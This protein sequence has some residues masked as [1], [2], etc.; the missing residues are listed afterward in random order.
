MTWTVIWEKVRSIMSPLIKVLL[1]AVIGHMIVTYTVRLMR[2]V[3]KRSKLDESLVRFLEKTVNI[4]LHILVV[5]SAL[6]SVG[7]STG[8]FVAA[9]SAVAV[10]VA[11]AL[12][13]SLGNVAG[14]IFLLFSPRFSTGDYI[15]VNGDGGTVVSIELF[16]TTVRTPDCREVSIPNGV[17]VNEHIINYSH[18]EVR[19]CDVLFS[20]PYGTDIEKA[21]TIAYE[22]IKRH[23]L[24]LSE[25]SEPFVRVKEYGESAVTFQTRTWCKTSDYWSLYYDIVE[26]IRAEL[27]KNG[28]GVP[29]SRLDVRIKDDGDDVHRTNLP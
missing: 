27:D 6:G 3:L 26:N 4:V 2:R 10:A 11:V 18:S 20:V 17:L 16:H 9:L 29:Y 24:A 1:I 25:P 7:V 28:I 15:E 13:D 5:L 23:P 14:G 19:R 8:G 12:K 21:K 22:T